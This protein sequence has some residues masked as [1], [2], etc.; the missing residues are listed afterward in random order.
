MHQLNKINTFRIMKRILLT[1]LVLFLCGVVYVIGG[2]RASQDL[3]VT[4]Y[5]ISAPV[6]SSIR[7]VQ[8]T[9]L[10][11]TE[12]G[13]ENENLCDTIR[14]QNPD[15]IFITGDMLNKDDPNTDIICTLVRKLKEIAPVYYG[16]GNHEV[17][18]ETLYGESLCKCFKRRRL[19][20]S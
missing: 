15:L 13:N 8:I 17:S 18:W 12:F 14:S 3:E 4:D 11:N 1:F 20:Q 2:I 7:I 16:Y 5:E 9:D 19:S 6:S 10:H